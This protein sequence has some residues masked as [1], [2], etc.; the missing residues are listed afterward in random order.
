MEYP[1]NPSQ[2]GPVQLRCL[3]DIG[4]LMGAI[5]TIPL[6]NQSEPLGQMGCPV[7]PGWARNRL[8]GP[9]LGPGGA[10]WGVYWHP[11]LIGYPQF[12]ALEEV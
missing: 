7:R 6:S 10:W 11:T 9:W 8:G 12:Y 1:Q 5:L 3:L 4:T 2:D